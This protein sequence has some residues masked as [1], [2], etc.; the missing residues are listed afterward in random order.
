MR[1]YI[2]DNT[3][4]I[5][6]QLGPDKIVLRWQCLSLEITPWGPLVGGSAITLA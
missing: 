4:N 2:K 6:L 1:H 5:S 3:L